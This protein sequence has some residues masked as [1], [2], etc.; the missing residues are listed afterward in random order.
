MK[1]PYD[2]ILRPVMTEQSYENAA[3]RKYTFIVAR[4]ANKFDIKWAVETIFGVKVI[5]VNTL[6][7]R[8]K[9]KRMGRHEGYRATTKRAIVRVTPDSPPIEFFDSAIQ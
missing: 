9:K 5:A 4:N 1:T 2:V 3:D 7:R 8:G 6:I